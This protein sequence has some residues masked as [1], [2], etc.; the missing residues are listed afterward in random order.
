V[1]IEGSKAQEFASVKAQGGHE[2]GMGKEQQEDGDSWSTQMGLRKVKGPCS[3]ERTL[4]V[5]F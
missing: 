4:C 5:S 3:P 2:L 1:K